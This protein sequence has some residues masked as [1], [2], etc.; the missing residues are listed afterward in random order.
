MESAH[1]LKLHCIRMMYT[2]GSAVPPE[3]FL[4]R[5]NAYMHL[6]M[7]YFAMADYN[8]ASKILKLSGR[9]DVECRGAV[10]ALPLV[11][12]GTYPAIDTHLTMLVNPYLGPN[13][14]VDTALLLDSSQKQSSTKGRGIFAARDLD[15]GEVVL[16]PHGPWLLYPLYDGGCSYCGKP[17]GTRVFQCKNERCHEEYCSRPCR[18]TAASVYHQKVCENQMFQSVELDLYAQYKALTGSRSSQN[19]VAAQLLATRIIAAALQQQLIPSAMPEVRS[20]VGRI[21]FSPKEVSGP[22]LDVYERL[23]HGCG[24]LT[25][26]S[27]EEY[28]SLLARISANSFHE[29]N[30]C[31][32]H[33]VPRAMLNHSCDAN[34]VASDS[35]LGEDDGVGFIT[36]RKVSR[37]AELCINYY[38]HLK[39]LGVKER[40]KEIRNISFECSCPRC[41]EEK[42]II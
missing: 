40:W 31:I 32:A 35:T 38:P 7:P 41:E 33:Y 17:L 21:S 25:S 11:L 24:F 36:S 30:N 23:A 15:A 2:M 20:L 8:S 34:V 3:T 29:N 18:H 10:D 6:Q 14:R 28:F 1:R 4:F 12:S 16:A 5:A 42:K 19:G 9:H 39:H 27:F 37:G 22:I 26:I 13:V